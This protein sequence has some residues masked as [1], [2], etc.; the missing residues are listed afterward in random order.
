MIEDEDEGGPIE[1]PW[2]ERW[3]LRAIGALVA[4]VGLALLEWWPN[5][6]IRLVQSWGW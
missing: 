4:A 2:R 1:L 6:S 5:F 3:K